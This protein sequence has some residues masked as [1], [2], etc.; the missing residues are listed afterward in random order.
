MFGSEKFAQLKN[1]ALASVLNFHSNRRKTNLERKKLKVNKTVIFVIDETFPLLSS[2]ILTVNSCK[3][4]PATN[5]IK[6]KASKYAVFEDKCLAEAWCSVSKDSLSSTDSQSK[7]FW[8]SVFEK[9]H[10]LSLNF[11]VEL[12]ERNRSGLTNR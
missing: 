6:T 4:D 12:E 5:L 2:T 8:D 11:D 10:K 3:M 9:Y 1:P 7:S